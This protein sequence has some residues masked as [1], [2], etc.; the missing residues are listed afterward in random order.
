MILSHDRKIANELRDLIRE[1]SLANPLWGA[2]HIHGELL[3]LGIEVAQSTVSKYMVR[4]RGPRGQTWSTFLCNH[5]D[6]IASIDLFVVPTIAFKLLYAFVIVRHGRRL[7]V[8]IGVTAHPTAEWLTPRFVGSSAPA[9][10]NRAREMIARGY[11]AHRKRLR[12]CLG[13]RRGAING[14]PDPKIPARPTPNARTSLMLMPMLR[15]QNYASD[16]G[17]SDFASPM[18]RIAEDYETLAKR[19][20]ERANERLTPTRFGSTENACQTFWL[21]ISFCMN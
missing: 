2:P 17:R 4:G 15:A 19:A 20:E 8:S 16:G 3:L 13:A 9:D 21:A 1:I 12:E 14:N 5:A 10:T 7:L 11:A 6:A 18:L